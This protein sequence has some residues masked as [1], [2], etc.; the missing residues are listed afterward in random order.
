MVVSRYFVTRTT[1]AA[2][3]STPHLKTFWVRFLGKYR[4]NELR[5]K[6]IFFQF[7]FLSQWGHHNCCCAVLGVN[8]R[9]TD[10]KINVP[11]SKIMLPFFW[12]LSFLRS[13]VKLSPSFDS[14]SN[15]LHTHVEGPN[16]T[17]WGVFSR[18][19]HLCWS[20]WT[21]KGF[22]PCDCHTKVHYTEASSSTQHTQ[23]YVYINTHQ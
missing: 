18:R 14:T 2:Q 6:L 8:W 22:G 9:Q 17:V 4:M 10:V 13:R 1:K 3:I 21:T 15:T 19:Y 23:T 20:L 7:M 11:G 5:F 16:R 12:E